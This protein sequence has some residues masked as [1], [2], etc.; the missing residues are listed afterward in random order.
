MAFKNNHSL[1]NTKNLKLKNF[2][3]SLF[4]KKQNECSLTVTLLLRNC[5]ETL[6]PKS[7]TAKSFPQ[8]NK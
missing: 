5:V 2:I 4:T 6:L 7:L 1:K 3:L 8:T